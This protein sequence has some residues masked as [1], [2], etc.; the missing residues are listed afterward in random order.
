M[1][2]RL[3]LADV[4]LESVN[5]L[6]ASNAREML[7]RLRMVVRTMVRK[8]GPHRGSLRGL[9]CVSKCGCGDVAL[10]DLQ[11]RRGQCRSAIIELTKRR[12]VMRLPASYSASLSTELFF[13]DKAIAAP[14]VCASARRSSIELLVQE[15]E[16]DECCESEAP[17]HARARRSPAADSLMSWYNSG[18]ARGGVPE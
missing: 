4:E 3:V 15:E 16:S 5:A 9:S 1:I 13:R 14:C 7:S 18:L 11:V 17:L 6:D 12:R 8:N 2:A 10:L